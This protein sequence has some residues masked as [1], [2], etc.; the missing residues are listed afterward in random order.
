[1]FVFGVPSPD[2]VDD[3]RL[4]DAFTRLALSIANVATVQQTNGEFS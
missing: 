4:I 3:M 2:S 1:M